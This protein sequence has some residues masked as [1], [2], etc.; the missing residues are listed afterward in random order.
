MT[1]PTQEPSQPV[2]F[3]NLYPNLDPQDREAAQERFDRYLE[4]VLRIY[5]RVRSDPDTY[6][7]FL[8]LTGR[9]PNATM[10]DTDSVVSG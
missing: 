1:E 3:Q 5:E 7:R 4:I 10:N 9:D 2:T 6:R 8:A